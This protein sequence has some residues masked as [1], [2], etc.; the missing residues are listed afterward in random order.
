MHRGSEQD[1]PEPEPAGGADPF[2]GGYPVPP[3]PGQTLKR[4]SGPVLGTPAGRASLTAGT[5]EGNDADDVR[6]SDAAEE[7]HHG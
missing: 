7:V 3:M 1:E 4:T 2:A 5:T 6:P